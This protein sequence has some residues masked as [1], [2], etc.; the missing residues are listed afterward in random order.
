VEK[1]SEKVCAYIKISI[2]IQPVC[3]RKLLVNNLKKSFILSRT[4]NNSIIIC[5]K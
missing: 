2:K 4:I 3:G 5:D 1:A